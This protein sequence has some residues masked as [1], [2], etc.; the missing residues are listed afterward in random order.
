MWIPD[1]ELEIISVCEAGNLEET[2]LFDA[3]REISSKSIELAK[4]VAAFANTAGGTIIFGI[5][6]DENGQPRIPSPINLKGQKERIDSIIRTSISEAP[7]YQIIQL[8]SEIESSKGYLILVI[9]PS[10]RAPHMVVV[11]GDRRFYGRGETGNYV[12]SEVE[13]ARLYERREVTRLNIIPLLLERIAESPIKDHLGF[14]HLHL[15]IKPALRG[16]DLLSKGNTHNQ[17]VS[18]YLNNLAQ[19]AA[20]SPDFEKQIFPDF[21]SGTW[22]QQPNGY[23]NEMWKTQP[24]NSSTHTLTVEVD[25]DGGGYLFCSRAAETAGRGNTSKLFLGELVGGLTFKL[26]HLFGRFYKNAQYYGMVDISIGLTGLLGSIDSNLQNQEMASTY[27]HNRAD[28]NYAI[29]VPASQ[30]FDDPI[31]VARELT[32]PIIDTI[33][34]GRNNPFSRK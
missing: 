8:E 34:Q 3:K 22:K 9:P 18:Q 21:E 23:L 12:F 16:D 29:R 10:A 28:Y 6:E 2:I 26:V 17:T 13:V 31:H 5:D 14:A 19:E 1:S 33:C 4:D 30:L 11:K 27:R 7:A 32:M 24:G 15:L 20:A 25:R